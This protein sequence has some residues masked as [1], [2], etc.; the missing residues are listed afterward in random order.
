LTKKFIYSVSNI[1]V[2]KNED[3]K[4][5]QDEFLEDID[6]LDLDEGDEE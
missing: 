1:K 4:M 2:E 5:T 6:S 3:E